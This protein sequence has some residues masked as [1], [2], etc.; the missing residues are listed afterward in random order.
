VNAPLCEERQRSAQTTMAQ[1]KKQ[2][3]TQPTKQ[4]IKQQARD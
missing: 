2:A 1:A 4:A 3:L